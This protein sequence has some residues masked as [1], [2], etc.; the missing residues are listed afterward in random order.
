M[1]QDGVLAMGCRL[2][3]LLLS[4]L[5]PKQLSLRPGLWILSLAFLML[6]THGST[7][8]QSLTPIRV[9]SSYANVRNGPGTSYT[10]IG[11][12]YQGQ[13]FVPAEKRAAS[14]YGA[15]YRIPF[16]ATS[17][18]SAWGWVAQKDAYGT[19]LVV[20]DSSYSSQVRTIINDDGIG[21][22]WRNGAS[23]SSSYLQDSAGNALKTWN[24]QQ[25]IVTTYTTGP[26]TCYWR[27][28]YVPKPLNS[29]NWQS[30]MWLRDD[31]IRSTATIEGYVRNP[32]GQPVSGVY[33]DTYL[34]DNTFL[35]T[36]TTDASGFYR[37]P[38]VPACGQVN[39][40]VFH[41]SY[42]EQTVY[43]YN[44]SPGET[45]RQ[46]IT[47]QPALPDLVVTYLSGPSTG[48]IGGQIAVQATVRNQGYSAAGPFRLGF[49]FSTD[50]LITSGD[51]FSGW[52]CSFSGLNSSSSTSCSGNIG[53]PASLSPGTY[54][55]GA[56]VDDLGQVS[57]G[58]ENNN[59]R[60][61]DTGP[62]TILSPTPTWTPTP[63]PTPTP[64]A[65]PTWTPTPTP[66]PTPTATPT[67]TPT[68]TPTLTPT[69]GPTPKPWTFMLYLDGDNNL[70]FWLRR[71]I[72]QM[73][74]Q[75]ANPN[76]NIIVLF[77]GDRKDDSWRFVVQ[78]RG[79]YIIGVNKWFMGELN[80]GDPQTLRDFILWARENYPAQHYYLAIANH[81]RG[82]TG[83]AWDGWDGTHRGDWQN[84]DYLSVSELRTALKQ[85]T[86]SGQWKIDVL[87]YDAC[88]MALFENAYQIK[89]YANYLVA[90]QNLGWSVFAYAQY[91]QA[92]AAGMQGAYAP[93]EFA[94]IVSK[95]T[96]ST[97]PQ[98]LAIKVA[99]AYFNHPAIQSYPR[100]IS[101]LDLSKAN[102]V[103]Q[104]MNAF[105]M[106]LRNN[107][108]SIKTYVQ[109]ARAATQKFDSRD[110]FKITDDDEY[111][112]LYHFAKKVK[113]YV[114]NSEVQN[115]AQAVM[116]ALS[117]GFVVAEHHQSGKYK[118]EYW[119]L[120]NAHG[121]SI[122][123]P[124]KPGSSDYSKYIDHQLFQFTVDGQWDEF[125]KDYFGVLGLPPE[126][127][128]EPEL[129]PMLAP[130]FKIYLPLVIKGE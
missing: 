102:S 49:Y 38:G 34:P 84:G 37:I 63:T 112:D 90:S 24:G 22:R 35:R 105:S 14:T 128:T 29:Y 42:L 28:F 61:A 125:L 10:K 109:N 126:S 81:G 104:A 43:V 117:T 20:E 127:P 118:E 107:L 7:A 69:P 46:D 93:Y 19:I 65:T 95:V 129:P 75:S 71:A 76:V 106:A 32:S 47:I 25:W 110:Y 33:I 15:W 101:A 58:D 40:F 48:Q 89:D 114:Q 55:L 18:G 85:A 72:E 59:A 52:Y 121:I 98:E 17:S 94:T 31:A 39:L 27:S 45:R 66:T 83:M 74:G 56:I 119:D 11:E 130:E 30:T 4:S 99:D 79:E 86:N 92:G 8:A 54:Y 51:V 36:V 116:D 53:V 1:E 115:A 82:T 124:P 12:V 50:S 91:A 123:F 73:E 108:S 103:H 120:D 5:H 9:V 80:M 100:T 68:P 64:T 41:P 44:L 6:I 21:W 111:L 62:I 3:N 122:Y 97:T 87:H 113:Q 26:D 88:I 70:Y 60:A 67:W 77:D 57:E 96:A 23:S 16:P 2:Y 13:V 78:P